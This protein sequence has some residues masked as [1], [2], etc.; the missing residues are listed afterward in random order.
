MMQY[1]QVPPVMQEQQVQVQF[2]VPVP[3]V[4]QLEQVQVPVP[5]VMQLQQVQVPVPPAMLIPGHQIAVPEAHMIPVLTKPMSLGT[6][7]VV[8]GGAPV[9]VTG[10]PVATGIV[11]NPLK[12]NCQHDGCKNMAYHRCDFKVDFCGN[13]LFEGCGKAYCIEHLTLDISV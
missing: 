11:W 2:Q 13:K 12:V 6:V 9:K 5:P 1:Q 8:A 7:N 10:Y 3:P 4:M